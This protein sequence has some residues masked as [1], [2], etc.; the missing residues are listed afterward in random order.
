[1]EHTD[2]RVGEELVRLASADNFRDVTGPGYRTTDGRALRPGLAYRSNE[3]T[4]THEDAS[5]ISGL[6]V[7]AVF[8]LRDVREVEMHPD[9]EVPGAAWTHLE[10]K[11]IP[12][13]TVVDLAD[14]DQAVRVMRDVY[15]GFVEHPGAREAFS[16]LLTRVAETAEPVLF[17]C[18]AGKDRTGWASA[19]LLHVCGVSEDDVRRDYLLT[20]EV[21][22]ATRRKYLGLVREHLGE[23]KVEVYERVM[24]ADEQYLDVAYSTV[25]ERYGSL[26]AYL[27]AGLGLGDATLDALRVRLVE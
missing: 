12:M 19:L 1:M 10:V 25:A 27:G 17:H 8:D 18:T 20:N 2:E 3:L 24:V 11:G 7:T 16:T 4:L 26:E 15:R 21:S 9:T 13:D 5:T 22:S 6:G 14:R 23:D